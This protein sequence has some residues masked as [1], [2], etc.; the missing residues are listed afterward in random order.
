MP[1]SCPRC[2][3]P[4]SGA[5]T[6]RAIETVRAALGAKAIPAHQNSAPQITLDGLLGD[7][8]DLAGRR[9]VLHLGA[10][11]RLAEIVAGGLDL[12]AQQRIAAIFWQ[13]DGDSGAGVSGPGDSGQRWAMLLD[14]LSQLGF[15]HRRLAEEE[16]G[17]PAPYIASAEP[18]AV[19]TLAR[20]AVPE[21]P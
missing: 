14:S 15:R 7:R 20:D 19:V 12:L 5:G 3:S 6:P 9:I 16:G 21:I 17:R 8:T 10:A 1:R 11:P 2:G 4:P 13:V 18:A